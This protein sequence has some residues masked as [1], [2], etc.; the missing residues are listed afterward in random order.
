MARISRHVYNKSDINKAKGVRNAGEE[1]TGTLDFIC[2][3]GEGI[4]VQMAD[5][6]S[7]HL[8][9]L[10]G[11]GEDQIENPNGLTWEEI[12]EFIYD[13]HV[14]QVGFC[15]FFLGYDFNRWLCTMPQSKVA[16]LI[17]KEGRDAR[18]SKSDKLKGKILPV[19]LP[20]GW[21]IDMLG[22]RWMQIRQKG[23]HCQTYYCKCPKGPNM[24]ICDS[25]PF[26][27]TSF[28]NVIDPGKWDNPIVS[29]DEFE[30]IKEGKENRA[31]ANEITEDM[32]YYNRLE[33]TI[34][35]RVMKALDTGFRQMGIKLTARQWFGPGQAAQTWMK[36]NHIPTADSIES[37]SNIPKWYLEAAKASYFGGWFEIFMHGIIPGDS[38]EYDI[39]SAYPSIIAELPC[40]MHGHCDGDFGSPPNM[41]DPYTLVYAKVSSYRKM[42][43]SKPYGNMNCIGTMLHR[44]KTDRI[45]RPIRSEGWYWLHEIQ[46]AKRAGLIKN[47]S[48]RQWMRFNKTCDC[49][50]PIRNVKELYELRLRVNK[51]SPRGKAAKLAYNSMYG[52]FAQSVGHPKFAN[53]IYASLITA[54]CRVMI[55]N[56]IATHPEGMWGVAFVA[57]DAVCFLEEH[58]SLPLSKRLGEWEHK[59]H[60]NL[61]LFKP[62]V[63]WNDKTRLAIKENKAPIF[64]ARGV[65]AKDFAECL[66][67]IDEQF[68]LWQYA[69][70]PMASS[71]TRSIGWPY[72]VFKSGFSMTSCLQ[73]IRRNKWDQ[74][75]HVDNDC[76]F[77]QNSNPYDKR[78]PALF[79]E[80][81]NGR[82]VY[83]SMPWTLPVDDCKSKPYEKQFGMDDPWSQERLE[84]FGVTPD[85]TVPELIAEV[86]E[87]RR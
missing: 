1:N 13:H 43:L 83:R 30:S 81:H 16:R 52:K 31:D 42:D 18:R 39:N 4:N 7:K 40:L 76:E 22:M 74:A 56:A 77:A 46:A 54:G 23:C 26:F 11:V 57:T 87:V 15:G 63:Y 6:I 29:D 47:V 68:Q 55:L 9:V 72:V 8:Y 53:S 84:L 24:T 5:G 44:D 21:Q 37:L 34:L 3:D 51:D 78:V 62:G 14:Y 48:Y 66:E 60:S 71:H 82:I 20:H 59:Q 25:G 32:R 75:G 61:T 27:Q 17:T 79:P 33:N 85:G 19:D 36:K 49:P 73:A 41:N 67:D 35:A 70:P 28:L 10:F 45:L 2:L 64:K 58:P 12:L 50:P 69:I 86:L 38:D 80:N 65:N